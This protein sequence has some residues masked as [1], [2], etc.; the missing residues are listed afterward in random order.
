MVK[1]KPFG[2]SMPWVGRFNSAVHS[3]MKAGQA[4]LCP[5]EWCLRREAGLPECSP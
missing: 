1:P 4:G 2:C 3:K 5:T